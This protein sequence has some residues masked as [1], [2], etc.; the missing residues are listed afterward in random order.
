DYLLDKFYVDESL[1]ARGHTV[2]QADLFLRKL[3]LYF[4]KCFLLSGSQ[5]K[6]DLYILGKVFYPVD[7]SLF[8]PENILL[9]QS[10]QLRIG[11]AGFREELGLRNCSF[12]LE[13]M[14]IAKQ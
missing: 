14:E 6:I 10:L 5:F 13:K 7:L 2:Q 8:S 9:H 1:S 12:R 3:F 11:G 4:F